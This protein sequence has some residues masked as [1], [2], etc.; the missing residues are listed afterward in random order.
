MKEKF[1]RAIEHKGPV[2][3]QEYPKHQASVGNTLEIRFPSV[4]HA[5]SCRE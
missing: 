5:L 4:E 2:L 3:A 1:F